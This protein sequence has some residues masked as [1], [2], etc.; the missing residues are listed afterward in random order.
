MVRSRLAVPLALLL[1]FSGCA[2]ASGGQ[3]GP[4]S[5]SSNSAA[6]AVAGAQTGGIDGTVTDDAINPIADVEVALVD[7]GKSTRTDAGGKFSFS[8]VTPG[9]TKIAA[10]RL[11][12]ES[13]ARAVDVEADAVAKVSL[14]LV[15]LSVA[16]PTQ[17][18]LRQ[19]G[20]IG[21]GFNARHPADAGGTNSY[22]AACGVLYYYVSPDFDRFRLDWPLGPTKDMSGA[23][24]ET[25]WKST[26]P[27]G[28]G[29]FVWWTFVGG[30][31]ST[32]TRITGTNPLVARL[33]ADNVT[34]SGCAAKNCTITSFHYPYANTIG[35]SSPVDVAVTVQQRLTDYVTVFRGGELPAKFSA[36]PPS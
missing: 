13:V 32:I 18:T 28:H 4:A 1:A 27:A 6:P 30:T 14:I 5:P 29:L 11:G 3:G 23:W 26:Q 36:L 2:G 9:R 8:D 21:C 24:V 16:E 10:A 7:L 22:V 17:V 31:I 19:E 34:G 20:F 33:E 25:S 12:Y 15:A 35:P